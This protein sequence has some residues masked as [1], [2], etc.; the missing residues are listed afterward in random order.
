MKGVVGGEAKTKTVDTVLRTPLVRV[1]ILRALWVKDYEL[2]I[3][4]V[5]LNPSARWTGPSCWHLWII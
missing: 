2:K 3:H 1:E 5:W 4:V